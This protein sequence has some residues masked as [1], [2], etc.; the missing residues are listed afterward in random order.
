MADGARRSR[1]CLRLKRPMPRVRQTPP[2]AERRRAMASSDNKDSIKITLDD[3]AAVT[4]TEPATPA[5]QPASPTAGAKS[6]GSISNAADE[7][8]TGSETRGSI[9]LQGWFYLG[10]AGLLGA[11]IGWGISEPMF[12]DGEGHRWGNA[13]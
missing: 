1:A 2:I 7:L 9:L 3:L 13:W 4:L 6:Y 8:V 5:A 10:T 12:V 11:V